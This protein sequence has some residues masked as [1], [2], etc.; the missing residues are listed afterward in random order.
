MFDPTRFFGGRGPRIMGIVNATGDSFSEGALSAPETAVERALTLIS[1]GADLL[2]IGGESTRPGSAPVPVETE[3]ARVLPV[4]EAVRKA[5]PGIPLSCDTRN[6]ETARAALAAG[7]DI[8]NDVGL[9]QY[10]PGTIAAAAEAGAVLVL[11]HSRGVPQNMQDVRFFDYGPDPV[12]TVIA[13]LEAAAATAVAAGVKKENIWFDPG[14]GFAKGA[15]LC[16]ELV[17]RAGEF[18]GDFR[19]LWGVSRKTFIG[20]LTAETEPSRRLGG[21]LAVELH[22][23]G[24]GADVIRTHDVRQLRA[25]LSA[26]ARINGFSA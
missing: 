7:C 16:W 22:L 5:A 23:A 12:K 4:I 17:A 21:T 2:D 11:S 24:H 25:A 18:A 13:E 14:I 6:G 8:V 19:W 26:A 9:G 15:D 1:D 10:D 20:A 3:C